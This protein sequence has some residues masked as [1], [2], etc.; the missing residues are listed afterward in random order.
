MK[1]LIILTTI[2]L[3]SC[4]APK[5][6]TEVDV[7]YEELEYAKGF[8]IGHGD[9]FTVLEVLNP[10]DTAKLL[11]RYVLVSRNNEIPEHLPEGKLIKTPVKR[12]AASGT[13]H[14]ALL[15]D[16]EYDENIVAVCEPEHITVESVTSRVQTGEVTNLGTSMMPNAELL[17]MSDAEIMIVSPFQN[18]NYAWAEKL[19]I[20]LVECAAY[21]ENDPL[22]QAEW[23]KFHAIFYGKEQIADSIFQEVTKN[24]IEITELT[25]DITKKPKVLAEKCYGQTW[26]VAAGE[27][28]AAKL[29]K[30]AGADYI[31]ADSE[32]TGSLSQSFE[33]VF[34]LAHDAEIWLIRYH[35]PQED[36]TYDMLKSENKLYSEFSAFKNKTIYGCNTARTDYYEKSTFYPNIILADLMKALHPSVAE[37]IE[38]KYYK[39]IEK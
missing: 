1:Y 21:L 13:I 37:N 10:W 4:N 5:E 38:A 34:D 12:I 7:T 9:G 2:L 31:W 35:N 16:F 25:K 23:I 22:G 3:F 14:C 26:W 8:K 24:Y 6:K 18:Q 27:S 30:D 32:G 19:E 11:N 28:Y 17:V 15:Q 39:I 33:S 36:L 20:P 29:Y